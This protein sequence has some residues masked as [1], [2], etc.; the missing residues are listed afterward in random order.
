MFVLSLGIIMA[1]GL[2]PQLL[3][4]PPYGMLVALGFFVAVPFILKRLIGNPGAP[5][6]LTKYLY[7]VNSKSDSVS[8]KYVCLVCDM[9]H[10]KRE[11]PRCGST[12]MKTEFPNSNPDENKY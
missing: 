10:K 3:L 2:A 11:C 12:M 1:I 4:P 6:P 5:G 7:K 9:R 8:M